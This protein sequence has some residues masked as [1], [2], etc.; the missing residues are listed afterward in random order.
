MTVLAVDAGRPREACDQCL[1]RV[2][3]VAGEQVGLRS[4]LAWLLLAFVLLWLKDLAGLPFLGVLAVVAGALAPWRL[5]RAVHDVRETVHRLAGRVGE[6]AAVT[7][8][9]AAGR[10]SPLVVGTRTW[11]RRLDAVLHVIRRERAEQGACG[12]RGHH[13]LGCLHHPLDLP[14]G[15]HELRTS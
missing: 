10:A 11:L 5:A 14:A 3:A 1:D 2:A 6:P 7:I 15:V 13:I 8:L 12:W 9:S 4:A